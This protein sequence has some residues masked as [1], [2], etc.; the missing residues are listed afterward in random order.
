MFIH[1]REQLP[2]KHNEQDPNY[3]APVIQKR[4]PMDKDPRNP[5]KRLKF[6]QEFPTQSSKGILTI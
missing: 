2:F 3:L 5:L 1:Q 4:K 6:L